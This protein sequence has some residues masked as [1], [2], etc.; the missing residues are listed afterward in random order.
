MVDDRPGNASASVANGGSGLNRVRAL[1]LPLLWVLVSILYLAVAKFGLSIPWVEKGISPVWPATGVAL[2]AVMLLGYRVWPGIVLGE[3]INLIAVLHFPPLP[4]LL[5]SLG[6]AVE[7]SLGIYLYRRSGGHSEF[8]RFPID[9]VRFG[10]FAGLVATAIGAT[11]GTINLVLGGI[12]PPE[13]ASKIWMTWWLGDAI[14]AIALTPVLVTWIL[15]PRMSLDTR[16]MLEAGLLACLMTLMSLVI[17][18]D[19]LPLG[20]EH[21]SVDFILLPALILA[22]FR[23]GSRGATASLLVLLSIALMGT[24]RGYG[25]FAGHPASE[26][27]VLLQVFVAVSAVSILLFA[28]VINERRRA[29]EDLARSNS[30]LQKANDNLKEVDRLKDHL[31]SGFSHEV[32]TPVSLLVAYSELLS[33]KY[34][35]EDL[36]AGIQEGSR[37]LSEHLNRILD[38]NALLSGCLTL[39]KTEVE[40]GE[41]LDQL[42][43]L[44]GKEVMLA[45]LRFTTVLQPDTPPIHGDSRRVLQILL[46]LVDNARKFTPAGGAIHV[47]A[48]PCDGNVRLTVCDSGRGIPVESRARIWERASQLDKGDATRQGGLGLGLTIV[49]GLAELHGGWVTVEG[50]PGSGCCISAYLPVG[51]PGP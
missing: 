26:S 39:F 23:F 38:F 50:Q 19:W 20:R 24:A 14:G 29:E 10:L 40:P 37:R 32:K 48:G 1:P 15:E 22:T 8:L 35:E 30:D 45:G 43:T 17:F 4:A 27:L 42:R 28:S 34:P 44:K 41:I 2:A 13:T 47:S 3:F 46:E 5:I 11:N 31:L 49:K 36:L 9:V 21:Y 25:P 7:A 16:K 33:E 6:N 12:V 18:W 51:S